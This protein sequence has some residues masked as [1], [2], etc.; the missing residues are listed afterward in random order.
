[1]MNSSLK[2]TLDA[3]PPNLRREVADFAD[4]LLK[5]Y[6]SGKSAA[7]PL[8]GFAGVWQDEALS[9]EELIPKRT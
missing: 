9:D 6:S 8:A 2:S 5:K 1:M 3:L 7:H 4:F